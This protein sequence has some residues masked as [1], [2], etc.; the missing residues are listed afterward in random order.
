MFFL[1]IVNKNVLYCVLRPAHRF[2]VTRDFIKLVTL[3]KIPSQWPTKLQII[4]T[5]NTAF[6]T[7]VNSQ[8]K[9]VIKGIITLIAY[10]FH[11][12]KTI[13]PPQPLISVI[14]TVSRYY[15]RKFSSNYV[16]FLILYFLEAIKRFSI[17]LWQTAIIFSCSTRPSQLESWKR[18]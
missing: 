17:S 6:W 10:K 5:S 14:I 3:W 4:K 12:K 11:I 15:R 1:S 7:K 8:S 9:N 16:S 13:T 2:S 18:E